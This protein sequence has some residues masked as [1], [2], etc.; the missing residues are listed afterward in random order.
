MAL[1][2]ETEAPPRHRV[3]VVGGGFGGIAAVRELKRADCDVTLV[4]RRNFHLFQ[5]L[6]YQV[7][8]SGLSPGEIASPL[9]SLFKRQKNVRVVLA[10]V[11]DFDLENRKVVLGRQ[12]NA[13]EGHEL[14]YDSLVVAAGARHSYFGNDQWETKAPGLK[15][16]EDAL[17]IRRRILRAFE[18]AELEDDPDSRQAWLTFVVVGGGPTGVEMAGQIAEISN[19]TLKR[20]FRN[21]NPRDAR[22]VL[23]EAADRVLTPYTER[24][25]AKAAKSLEDLGVTLQLNSMVSEIEINKVTMQVGDG[26]ESEEQVLAANTVIWAAGVEASPLGERLAEQCGADVDRSGRILVEPDLTLPG[27]PDVF[28]IGDMVRVSD[29]DGGDKGIPGVAQPAIQEGTYVGKAIRRTLR[30]GA[31]PEKDFEYLDKGSLATIGRYSAV[32]DIRGFRF[33][34]MPAWLAWLFVHLAFLVGMANRIV[35]LIRWTLS[36]VTYGR[37]ARLI[38]GEG[39]ET[40]PR[41]LEKVEKMREVVTSTS[42]VPAG[43]TPAEPEH[44]E[45]EQ[46][47]SVE[48]ETSGDSEPAAEGSSPPS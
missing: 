6:L 27:H 42:S 17:T 33:A 38:T 24:L 46:A 11:S 2:N 9:R 14:P 5:P 16:L 8:T 26:D 3:V 44:S 28:A 35:V 36:F 20:D 40:S 22:I 21:I 43:G 1:P 29:G 34:G 23:V 45:R 13:E 41:S 32:A 19:H 31:A 48:D 39:S 37:A 12:A 25:S 4:D 30:Y 15:T 7:A 18:A 10:E 47:P